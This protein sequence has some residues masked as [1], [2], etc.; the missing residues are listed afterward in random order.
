MVIS[1]LIDRFLRNF[2]RLD[3]SFFY[4]FQP[5]KMVHQVLTLFSIRRNW[6]TLSA[7][8]NHHYRDVR[9]IQSVRAFLVWFVIFGHVCYSSMLLPSVNPKDIE[10][11]SKNKVKI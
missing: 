6:C 2:Y 1:S 4:K 5:E 11:V 7:P 3:V 10:T 8:L 9:F